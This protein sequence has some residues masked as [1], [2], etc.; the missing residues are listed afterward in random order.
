MFV[1]ILRKGLLYVA[2]SILELDFLSAG[3]KGMCH[4]CMAILESLIIS[5]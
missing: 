5:I 3:I 1:C 2:W 4:H